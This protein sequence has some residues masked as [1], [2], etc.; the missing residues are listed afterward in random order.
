MHQKS[1][2]LSSSELLRGTTRTMAKYEIYKTTNL[3]TG[4]I[5]VGKDKRQRKS[6][7][8]SG[9][10]LKRSLKKHGRENFVKEIL[11]ICDTEEILNER[12]EF[13]IRELDA[14]NPEIG[15]NIQKGGRGGDA[16]QCRKNITAWW[17]KMTPEEKKEFSK[18]VQRK[19]WANV[20]EEVR[21]NHTAAAV[22]S[23][24]TE[25]RRETGKKVAANYKFWLQ[26]TPEQR[27]ERTR[28]SWIAR[29]QQNS[30]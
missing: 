25:E 12:E 20:S 14:R 3:L 4:K 22:K 9:T 28:K 1:A 18:R 19:R 27:S 26:T 11:E 17:S 15:Y 10:Y 24:S 8:G 6:Y 2:S 30:L 13:W 21:K 7:L 23:R 5:Y 29:K 16:E